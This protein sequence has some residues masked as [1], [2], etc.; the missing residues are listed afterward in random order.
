MDA[1]RLRRL[2][3]RGMYRSDDGTFFAGTPES[4][5]LALMAATAVAHDVPRAVGVE[6]TNVLTYLI[7]QEGKAMDLRSVE[8]ALAPWPIAWLEGDLVGIA[9]VPRAA[10]LV[11]SSAGGDGLGPVRTLA[12]LLGAGEWRADLEPDEG[13]T[14]LVSAVWTWNPSIGAAIGPEAVGVMILTPG[15]AIAAGGDGAPRMGHTVLDTAGDEAYRIALGNLAVLVPLFTFQFANCRNVEM[16]EHLPTRQQR[17]ASERAGEPVDRWYTLTI[18]QETVRRVAGGEVSPE[19]ARL[20]KRLH[21]CRGHFATY[22]PERPLFGRHVGRFWVPAHV[23]GAAEA[24]V[25]RKDYQM[26]GM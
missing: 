22:T 10:V 8:G 9:G 21:I 2:V 13:E 25:I 26:A 24:G 14:L 6:V 4:E 20:P 15:G 7:G 1:M 19:M 17:R 16:S 12:E 18:G 11:G 23:R 5:A 3:R